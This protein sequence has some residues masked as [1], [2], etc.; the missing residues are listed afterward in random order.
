MWPRLATLQEFAFLNCLVALCNCGV[1]GRDFQQLTIG[2]SEN[3]WLGHWSFVHLWLRPFQLGVFSEVSAGFEATWYFHEGPEVST[4]PRNPEISSWDKP[5]DQSI[6]P[7]GESIHQLI[8]HHN[9]Y[10]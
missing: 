8:C 10:R 6:D 1:L 4:Y 3:L 2:I 5:D 9:F 7:V